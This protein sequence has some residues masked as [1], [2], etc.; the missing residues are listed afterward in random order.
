MPPTWAWHELGHAQTPSLSPGQTANRSIGLAVV[1][2]K[3]KLEAKIDK[4]GNKLEKLPSDLSRLKESVA[5]SI[6][7]NRACQHCSRDQNRAHSDPS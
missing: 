4:L 2:F 6:N 5:F 1:G 3:E 7:P